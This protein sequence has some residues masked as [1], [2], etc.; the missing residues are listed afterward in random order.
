MEGQKMSSENLNSENV[1][2][3]DMSQVTILLVEIE[4][5]NTASNIEATGSQIPS[6]ARIGFL[7]DL[8]RAR[9]FPLFI[10]C[11][12]KIRTIFATVLK[13]HNYIFNLYFMFVF[14]KTAKCSNLFGGKN[15]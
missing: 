1:Q 15:S 2:E 10:N 11:F 12:Y 3:H 5:E 8:F 4:M 6:V 13:L 9:F 14:N 7:T